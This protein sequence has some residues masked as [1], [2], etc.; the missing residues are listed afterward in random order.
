MP[1]PVTGSFR[2]P[3]EYA[4]PLAPLNPYPEDQG[5]IYERKMAP[6]LPG[7]RGPLRFE[8]GVATDT[9]VPSDFTVGALQGHVTAPGRYNRVAKSDT[10]P[11]EETVAQ[12]AHVGSAA[13]PTAPTML[14]DFA[15]GAFSPNAEQRYE[16]PVR[17]GGHYARPN[18]A[19]V[20]D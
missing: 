8:E 10:K 15:H 9:D 1:D 20:W 4:S 14:G 3:G 12:R 11:P 2:R 7:G 19:N 16:M 17:H 6:N 13:W 5:R 18:P